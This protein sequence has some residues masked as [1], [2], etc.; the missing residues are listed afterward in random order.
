MS[1]LIGTKV[2]VPGTT[3]G[4]GILKYVGPIEGKGGVFGGL[5]LQGP[6]AASRGKNNGSVD[7]IQYFNVQ[8]P[9]SG[10]FIPWERLRSANLRLPKL[11]E[12]MRPISESSDYLRTPSPRL[13]SSS[14]GSRPASLA[15]SPQLSLSILLPKRRVASGEQNSM[16]GSRSVVGS[17]SD[18]GDLF[19]RTRVQHELQVA[20]RENNELRSILESKTRDLQERDNILKGLQNT[21]NELQAVLAD[22]ED[23]LAQKDQRLSKQKA[24]ND[25]AREEWRESLQLML[26]AQ[27]EAEEL[28]EQQLK[29]LKRKLG[30]AESGSIDKSRLNELEE[31]IKHLTEE[32][33]RLDK[34]LERYAT[35]DSQTSEG[36]EELLKSL[37]RLQQDVSSLEF[38]LG[39]SQEKVKAKDKEILELQA[40]VEKLQQKD[41]DT[42]LQQVGKMNVDE[43]TPEKIEELE[44]QLKEKEIALKAKRGLEIELRNLQSDIEKAEEEKE[45][46]QK[47]LKESQR[48]KSNDSTTLET[49]IEDLKHELAMRPTF[50]ELS[51]LQTSL[52]EVDL[53]HQ[54]SLADKD[55]A[56]ARIEE[57]KKALS[58]ELEK[59]RSLLKRS[60]SENDDISTD[61]TENKENHYGTSYLKNDT[62]GIYKPPKPV[63]PSSG[64]QNWCGLCERDGLSSL[65]CPYENDIF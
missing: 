38:V 54:K 32:N 62:L 11:D 51:E 35:D 59:L 39:E 48:E 56:L 44:K 63:D 10:L 25:K 28:Y 14:R 2:A 16:A 26:S 22:M 50:E 49:Q 45:R 9:M 57:E 18:L 40:E 19:D 47:Q 24:D 36:K 37:E 61:D 21:I 3:R 1:E 46:L 43:E 6:I 8:Q 64:R 29:D 34:Q 7:G 33:K 30:D 31:Q 5:E 60:P 27:Q 58:E 42:L 41:M 23:E 55:R 52:E 13:N 65:N 15:Q 17:R 20:Q 12:F 4:Y 53:L